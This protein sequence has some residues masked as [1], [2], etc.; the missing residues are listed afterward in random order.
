[1]DARQFLSV[2]ANEQVVDQAALARCTTLFLHVWNMD[3]EACGVWLRN[4]LLGL[5]GVVR[6]DAFYDRGVVVVSY[7]PGLITPLFLLGVVRDVGQQVHRFYSAEVIGT[8]PA[9]DMR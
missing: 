8:Q 7:S 3:C 5:D 2:E 4:A 9:A 6:V 1:M